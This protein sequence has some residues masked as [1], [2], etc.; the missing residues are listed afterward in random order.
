L[1]HGLDELITVGRLLGKQPENDQLHVA[2]IEEA[3]SPFTEATI[4]TAATAKTMLRPTG[5][6]APETTPESPEFSISMAAL[7]PFM[8]SSFR[9]SSTCETTA[10]DF[11]V[12]SKK[13]SIHRYLLLDTSHDISCDD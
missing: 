3:T 12:Y 7:V 4:E 11:V 5:P 13:T 8:R 2:G 10:P 6:T 1:L 9:L